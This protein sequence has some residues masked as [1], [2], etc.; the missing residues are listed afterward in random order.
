MSKL[1]VNATIQARAGSEAAVRASLLQ[2]L[3]PTRAEE[4]CVAYDLHQDLEDPARF[5]FHET[6][7]SA[8]HLERHLASAHITANR[9]RIGELIES[10]D[11]R[12][13]EKLG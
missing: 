13:L 5:I 4:G 9:E 2:L 7:E 10:L 6:W 3:A 11:V 1:T 12:K 8:E